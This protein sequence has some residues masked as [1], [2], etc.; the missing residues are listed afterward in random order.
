M[1]AIPKVAAVPGAA[2]GP[3]VNDDDDDGLVIVS[4]LLN[5]PVPLR[6]YIFNYL[7]ETQDELIDLTLISKQVHDDCYRPG[8]E[9]KIIPTI[10]ISPTPEGGVGSTRALLQRLNNQSP[11]SKLR[12]YTHMKIN[13]IHR[14]ND[15]I[16]TTEIHEIIGDAEMDWIVSLDMSL[17]MPNLWVTDYFPN[18]LIYILPNLR[19]IDIS[20][21]IP[22]NHSIMD[23]FFECSKFEKVTWNNIKIKSYIAMDGTIMESSDNLKEVIMDDSEFSCRL[24]EI[25]TMSDLENHRD[26]FI[27]HCCSTAL[28]RVSIRNAKWVTKN[29]YHRRNDRIVVPQNA[30]IKFVRNAPA[31]LRWFRSDLTIENMNMLRLE[32]PT[33]E[34]L[35]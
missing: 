19:E 16:S 2:V 25:D 30:L 35:N 12:R 11:K 31:S 10:V 8:I 34:L 27:F 1:I 6:V 13:D 21:N 28:E 26:T 5:L 29:H 32:R 9:W 14:F 7:G 23:V 20:Y 17:S 4:T 22:D 15:N 33:I 18:V 24:P 3:A